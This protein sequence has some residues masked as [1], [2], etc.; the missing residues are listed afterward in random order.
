MAAA[1]KAAPVAAAACANGGSGSR[2]DEY[3]YL[4]GFGAC[5]FGEQ[6]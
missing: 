3:E 2:A 5:R 4:S 1:V 6:R